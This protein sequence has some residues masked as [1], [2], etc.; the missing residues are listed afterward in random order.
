MRVAHESN[1]G[2]S[3]SALDMPETRKGRRSTDLRAACNPSPGG[4]FEAAGP[5][6]KAAVVRSELPPVA[7]SKENAA[8]GPIT[9]AMSWIAARFVEGGGAYAEGMYPSFV[10]PGRGIDQRKTEA[11]RQGRRSA[12]NEHDGGGLLRP[13][14][15]RPLEQGHGV[16]NAGSHTIAL[17]SIISPVARFWS[18]ARREWEVG[19]T[20]ATLQAL[21]DRTLRDLGLYRCQI[22]SVVRDAHRH[23]SQPRGR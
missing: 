10:H 18:W 17:V 19:R 6:G 20:I 11:T 15:G 9:R 5:T 16:R 8:Q 22:A 14:M 13:I 23:N 3:P 21:D 4:D 7:K 12:Q 2:G 1:H